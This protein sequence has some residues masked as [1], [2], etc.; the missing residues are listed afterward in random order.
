MKE[1]NVYSWRLESHLKEEL[2]RAARAEK[3]TVS[4]L[5]TRIATEW[6]RGSSSLPD[7]RNAQKRVRE[8]AAQYL[9]TVSG[10]D[11]SRSGDASRRV[12][13]ILQDKHATRRAD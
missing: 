9:G 11:P 3:T 7:D 2:E 13:Q 12:K 5:L 1:S 4:R 10:R 6:L 8:T